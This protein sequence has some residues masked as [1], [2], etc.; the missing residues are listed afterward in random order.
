MAVTG[1]RP[2]YDGIFLSA[3][4]ILNDYTATVDWAGHPP[5]SVEFRVNGT[6][7]DTVATATTE[8]TTTISMSGFSPAL[9]VGGN[10]ITAV[11]VSTDG[12][13]SAAF[14]QPVGMVPTPLFL[15]SS[16]SSLSAFLD[17]NDPTISMEFQFPGNDIPSSALH[18]L[19][20]LG[21]VGAQMAVGAG[22]EYAITTGEFQVHAGIAPYGRFAR[23]RGEHKNSS[24]L[25]PKLDLAN[26]EFQFEVMA[27]GSGRATLTRGFEWDDEVVVEVTMHLEAEIMRFYF[28]DAI[29]GAQGVGVILRSLERLGVDIGRIQ[30]VRVIAFGEIG[31]ELHPKFSPSFHWGDGNKLNFKPGIQAVYEPDLYIGHAKIYVGGSLNFICPLQPNFYLESAT[32]NIFLG[33]EVTWRTKILFKQE[34]L[35]VNSTGE[36]HV[37]FIGFRLCVAKRLQNAGA[38]FGID[39][40]RLSQCRVGAFCRK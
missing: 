21:K 32:L 28:T 13:R 31:A 39:A 11:A 7:R 5:G 6:L 20:F 17:R 26:V 34:Y 24:L 27:R 1:I 38:N 2:K 18:N 35:L 12:N 9:S 10:K 36:L 3:A 8:A 4:A 22:F 16:L 15:Q 19:P 40:A 29:P 37:A 25:R 14:E 33:A 23:Q 30:E